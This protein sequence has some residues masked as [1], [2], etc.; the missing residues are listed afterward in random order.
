VKNNPVTTQ[1]NTTPRAD[2]FPFINTTPTPSTH[3]VKALLSS[4]KT[5]F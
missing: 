5:N 3:G 2:H 1:N 4:V